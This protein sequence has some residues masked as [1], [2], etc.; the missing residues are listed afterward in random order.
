MTLVLLGAGLSPFN[1]FPKNNV[2][3]VSGEKA[4]QF[5]HH[6]IAY[7]T[8]PL[9]AEALVSS[10]AV[11]NSGALDKPTCSLEIRLRP[12]VPYLRGSG[13]LLVFYDPEN[14]LQFRLMQWHDEL[15]IRRDHLAENGH[16]KTVELELERV[17]MADEPVFFTIT[18]GPTRTIAYRNG[19]LAG[20][21]TRLGL[22]CTDFAGQLFLGNSPE[23]DYRWQGKLSALNIY[24]RELSA[25]DVKRNF[26]AFETGNKIQATKDPTLVASYVFEN[27][28]GKVVLNGA[29]PAPDLRI[30]AVFRIVHKKFLMLPSDETP[31]KLETRDILI[32]IFGLAPFGFLLFIYLSELRHWKHAVLATVLS[33]FALSMFIEVAQWFIPSR[34]S[35]L[36]DLFTNTFGTWLGVLAFHLHPLQRLAAKLK[37]LPAHVNRP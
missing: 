6:G 28:S 37:L 1:P 25:Q 15:L 11:S 16:F 34:S 18:S 5:G 32:N 23:A 9:G 7:T 31:D 29:G 14:P 12:H 8:Q 36:I 10:S 26:E 17:F 13:T 3:W 30:P 27:G 33:G 24:R 19:I 2:D 20:T 21:S 4:L 35:D 22:S